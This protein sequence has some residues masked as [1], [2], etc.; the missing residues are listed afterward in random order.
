MNYNNIDILLISPFGKSA[1]GIAKWTGHILDFYKETDHEGINIEFAYIE[2]GPISYATDSVLIR[3][4]NGIRGYIPL[5]SVIRKKLKKKH[6]KI[7]HICSSAS[8]GL[9]KDI[10]LILLSHAYN[11]KVIVHFRFGRIPELFKK[12]NWEQKIMTFVIKYS[13]SV[14]VLDKKSYETLLKEGYTNIHLLPNPL[15]PKIH[16]IIQK[17]RNFKRELRKLLFVG[18]MIPTK[19]IFELVESC[20]TI[21]DLYLTMVGFVPQEIKRELIARAGNDSDKWLDIKGELDY[22]STIREMLKANIFVFPTYTEGFP[23]VILESMACGCPIV[24]TNVGAIP[25]ML[26]IENG[27]NYGICIEP[28]NVESLRLAIQKMLDSPDYALSCGQNAKKRVFEQYS[29]S[30][31]WTQMISIWENTSK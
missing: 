28:K 17:N 5:F 26:D 14:I 13:D 27:F 16:D 11:S 20:K 7:V 29:M 2:N 22:E 4:R 15:T 25:E 31:I 9:F 10:V 6:Y 24:T 8:L 3:F 23:N 1:G 30:T 12:R 18:H 19:G 21:P